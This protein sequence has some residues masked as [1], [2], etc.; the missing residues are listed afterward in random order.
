MAVKKKSTTKRTAG[1]SNAAFVR[2]FHINAALEA[3][4]ALTGS[5]MAVLTDLTKSHNTFTMEK[6]MALAVDI[7][8]RA[9]ATRTA[10]AVARK[11][12]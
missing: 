2:N 7:L 10:V 4:D 8:V 1:I 12:L 5:L 9:G 11:H 3:S 6:G